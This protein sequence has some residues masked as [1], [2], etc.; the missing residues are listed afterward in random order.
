MYRRNTI[1]T[2]VIKPLFLGN[3]FDVRDY[4]IYM[5]KRKYKR[6]SKQC[7]VSKF[8]EQLVNT[9]EYNLTGDKTKENK[10]KKLTAIIS[11]H[12]TFFTPQKKH[13][14]NRLGL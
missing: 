12:I 1:S 13:L 11:G 9:T 4:L 5:Y 6:S 3:I 14:L 10:K 8:A 2:R 7:H